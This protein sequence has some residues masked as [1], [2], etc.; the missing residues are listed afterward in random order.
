MDQPQKLIALT[1]KQLTEV[2][3]RFAVFMCWTAGPTSPEW[4]LEVK[5]CGARFK[6]EQLTGAR[7]FAVLLAVTTTLDVLGKLEARGAG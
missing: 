6:H 2:S 5:K 7:E 4:A 3:T 1:P